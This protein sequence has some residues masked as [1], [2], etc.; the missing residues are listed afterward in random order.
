MKVLIDNR[1]GYG[2]WREIVAERQ[3]RIREEKER[4]AEQKRIARR[5][6]KEREE[7]LLVGGTIFA[8]CVI[9]SP[10]RCRIC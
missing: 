8:T 10:S 7:M 1:F 5:K 6:K 9:I 2:T 3:K 4:I